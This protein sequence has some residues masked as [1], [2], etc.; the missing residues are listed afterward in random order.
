MVAVLKAMFQSTPSGLPSLG[1]VTAAAVIALLVICNSGAQAQQVVVMTQDADRLDVFKYKSTTMPPNPKIGLALAGGGSRGSAQV[2]VLEVL[3]KAGVKF[4]FIT[5]TSIGAIVGGCY[6]AGVPLTKLQKDMNSGHLMR[7]FMTVPLTVRLA[8]EPI[9]ILP[10]LIGDRPYDG[11]YRGNKFRKYLAKTLPKG[12]DIQSL[13]IPFAACSLNLLDGKPY[14]IVGGD[15]ALAMQCSSAVP[16]LRKPVEFADKLLCDGGVICNL[17]VK[18]C[19]Q[20]G[21]EFVIAVNIDEPFCEAPK[22]S[23]KAAGSV[24]DRM[25]R[26]GLWWMDKP[27]EDIADFVIHPDTAGVT[28]LTTSRRKETMAYEAGLKAATEA[29]PALLAKLQSVGA[30]KADVVVPVKESAAN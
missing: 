20:L 3:E 10:R 9:M 13:K 5:G 19:R 17:P 22:E 26:W 23:F 12:Q 25:I 24:P 4:D 1:R 27:Q 29:L 2:A 30:M 11:L 8:A 15:L 28:L 6:A 16:G 14:M 18:Q 7:E 21:A